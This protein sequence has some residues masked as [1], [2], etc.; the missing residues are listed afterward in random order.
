LTRPAAGFRRRRL[1]RGLQRVDQVYRS[2]APCLPPSSS[3]TDRT[4]SSALREAAAFPPPRC[5]LA[6]RGQVHRV[7]SLS[8]R[9][10]AHQPA[11]GRGV[12]GPQLPVAS[13]DAATVAISRSGRP[14]SVGH[15]RPAAARPATRQRFRPLRAGRRGDRRRTASLAWST[16]V[17]SSAKSTGLPGTGGHPRVQM[18]GLTGAAPLARLSGQ[19]PPTVPGCPAPRLSTAATRRVLQ[20]AAADPATRTRTVGLAKLQA[21]CPLRRRLSGRL[22]ESVE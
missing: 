18:G 11:P 17:R 7:L 13:V 22:G 2:P 1:V 5:M 6:C 21:S 12:A 9:R 3:P 16:N 4:P 10:L 19:I 14:R 8:G 20:G 15:D